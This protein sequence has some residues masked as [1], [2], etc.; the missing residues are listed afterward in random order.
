M[1]EKQKI[2]VDAVT[3]SAHLWFIGWLFTIGFAQLGIGKGI[4]A[5]VLWP[6]FL[7]STLAG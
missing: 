1:G 4:L 2:E 6:Y 5:I 7:G 3:R